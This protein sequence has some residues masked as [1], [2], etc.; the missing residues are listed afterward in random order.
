MI[1]NGGYLYTWGSG[2]M[3]VTGHGISNI[4]S[5][6]PSAP[7]F[8]NSRVQDIIFTQVSCGKLTTV[9]VTQQG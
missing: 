7:K 9:A 4:I 3:G 2:E 1:T 5:Y 6:T 8:K